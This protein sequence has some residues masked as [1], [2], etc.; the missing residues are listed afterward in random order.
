[1]VPCARAR[2]VRSRHY[3][4]LGRLVGLT[5][6]SGHT[7]RWGYDRLGQLTEV[8]EA[9]GTRR[10]L[11][12]DGEGNV[13]RATEGARE[14]MYHY[15]ALNRLAARQQA[16]Q[17][18]QFAY[19]REGQLTG[20]V[21]EAGE[22]YRFGLNAA[23]QVVEEIGF[24][25]LTRRYARD[26]AGRV[27]EVQRPAGRMTRYGYDAAG[28]VTQVRHNDE[29]P[30]TYAYALTGALVEAVSAGHTVR[31]E[32]DALGRVLREEQN[33]VA[34]E[35]T[36]NVLG[37][38]LRLHSSL[39]AALTLARDLLGAVTQMQAGEWSSH[40][41]RDA[42]GLELHRRLSGGVR[43]SWQR[44]ALGRP[45]SQ[46][47]VAGGGAGQRGPRQRRYQWQ[48]ADKLLGIEDSLSGKTHYD[49]DAL[50]A[51]TAAHYTDGEQEL[52]Q[53][54]AVGNL[55]RTRE[56]T[57][58]RYGPGGQLREANGTRYRYDEEGNLVRKTLPNG[59][60]WRYAWDGAGQ[61]ACVSRPDGYAVTFTYDALG[62]RVSKRFRGRVTKWVWDG[63]KVLHEWSELEVGPGAGSAG[64]V[65]TWLFEEDS[66]APVAKLTAQGAY[67]VVCDHLG[68][69]LELYDAQGRK[70]WQAQLD[71]YGAVREGRGQAR[72]CP[73]RY[74][75][76]YEDQET[77]LYY[78]RFR[79][80]DPQTGSYISQD[81][82]G[83]GGGNKLYGY[84]KNP[85]ILIDPSGLNCETTSKLQQHA[86]DA[87][88]EAVLSPKQEASIERS[89]ARA[90]EATDP[91]FKAYH[92]MQAAK[93]ERL[94]RGTQIDTRFKAKVDAD[95]DLAHLSTT[96]RG[97][98]G[99]D[100]Y[101]PKA[102]K[103][104]D[105]TTE[106]DWNKGT[107]QGKYDDDF[108]VGTGIF[109]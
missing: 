99:P 8:Q 109:W 95:P 1:M 28:R 93:K 89:N 60:M 4:G 65:L 49:Y 32:R 48:G 6:A 10:T 38:R 106:K 83:L 25:G 19:D 98:V 66:F 94:Y 79:Y 26:A 52:R 16:G 87:K 78:N 90:R 41:E 14:V 107:H 29:A 11:A 18:V 62:R 50:G 76:Q 102:N 31:W 7:Q 20:L 61:L 58:R 54:D 39:G 17:Q 21:N 72:D 77:G 47:I 91:K 92:E 97:K 88:S 84:V 45:T 23:G 40:W 73:F 22:P 2:T 81:P 53:P 85:M 56:R 108:G 64:E 27:M 63:N 37:Q 13:R 74:Q 43:T 24:D 68:T 86:N 5:D 70:T 105:L 100:V 96:P 103:Y 35:S 55:F 75:G 12:Y 44:D 46:H 57:D 104:W 15:T 80:Y 51:L 67:S 69:P 34:I 30:T 42:E 36:Y 9:G 82:I 33:G 101:D 3:D 59:Q 71:S